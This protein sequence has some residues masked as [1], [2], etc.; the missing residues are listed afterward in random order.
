M[1]HS[2]AF[3]RFS[4]E[5]PL[6]HET[7]W[8]DFSEACHISCF[9]LVEM[10]GELKEMFTKDASV[11][12]VSISNTKATSYGYL[13]P[14][15]AML[16]S[17]CSYLAKSFS[18]FSEVRFNSVGAGPLKTSASSGIPNYIENYLYFRKINPKKE[19]FKNSRSGRNHPFSFK[20]PLFWN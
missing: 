1:L 16:E 19:K 9:S 4:L 10:A 15:K 7:S 17:C 6:F 2:L 18:S 13:G 11:V 8:S 14:I 12:T 20:S 5:S 3:A